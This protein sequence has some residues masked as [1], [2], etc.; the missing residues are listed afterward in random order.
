[1][2]ATSSGAVI[3]ESTV[4]FLAFNRFRGLKPPKGLGSP[5]QLPQKGEGLAWLVVPAFCASFL[6]GQGLLGET[7]IEGLTP[8]EAL[9]NATVVQTAP[10]F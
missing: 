10:L 9:N 3:S 4:L 7:N 2:F 1:M 8:S 6:R 5:L